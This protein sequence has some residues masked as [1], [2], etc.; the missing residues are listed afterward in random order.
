M[1]HARLA[2][3]SACLTALWWFVAAGLG[4]MLAGTA[5]AADIPT[6]TIRPAP[7]TARPALPPVRPEGPTA[8]DPP[9]GRITAAEFIR[10]IKALIQHGDLADIPAVER[11]LGVRIGGP[12]PPHPAV[13]TILGDDIAAP[14]EAR[15]EVY[16]P[17]P[18]HGIAPAFVEL[19]LSV[20]G[21]CVTLRDVTDAFGTGFEN[22][23]HIWP[24]IPNYP[25]RVHEVDM[26]VYRLR[27][28]PP[29]RLRVTFS[30]QRCAREFGLAQ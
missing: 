3:I 10:R 11:A 18:P 15:Y 9:A 14:R 12:H 21:P 17:M 24:G 23:R 28:E 5:C 16:P 29:L 2:T 30:G 7:D 22:V 1:A 26:A 8:S 13:R 6:V 19:R 4:A 20:T 27:E 25:S